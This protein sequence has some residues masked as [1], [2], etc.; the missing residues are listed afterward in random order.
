MK[1]AATALALLVF[2]TGTVHTA[3]AEDW[4][5]R[6]KRSF[7]RRG[8][9]VTEQDAAGGIREAMAQGVQRAVLQLGQRDGFYGDERLRIRAPGQL[10]KLTDTARQLGA[11]KQVDAFEL[12]MNRAAEEAVPLAAD[13]FADAVREMTVR[14]A[15]DIVRGEPDAGTRFFRR[16]TEDRLRAEFLPIVSEATAEAGVTQRYKAVVGRNSGLIN[17]LGGGEAVDLD[18][19]VTDEALDALFEVVAEQER[20][21]R[22]DPAQ[23]ST[24]LLRK[25]F[26]SR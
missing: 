5:D 22:E 9:A 24:E 11:G 25:V 16:V 8:S 6:L 10:R 3:Q 19:Y 12:S 17:A 23:R 7:D 4:K 1:L 13:V 14:D 26:G 20:E 15:L 2:A 21:I 18:R